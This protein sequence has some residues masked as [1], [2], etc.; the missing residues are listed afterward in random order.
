MIKALSLAEHEILTQKRVS[1]VTETENLTDEDLMLQFQKGDEA[2][3]RT[4]VDRHKQRVFNLTYRFLNGSSDAE[5]L[6]QEIFMKIY[7]SKDTYKP[8]AK[9]TTWLFTITR[10]ACFQCLKK[11]GNMVSLNEKAGESKEELLSMVTDRRSEN[12]S[13]TCLEE[14]KSKII[15]DAV[16]KLPETQRMVILL[17]RFEQLSYEEIAEVLGVTVQSVK[18]LLFRGRCSLKELLKEY[19]NENI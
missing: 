5:D 17:R 2:C 3:F 4:L 15:A 7:F 16:A 9:F 19:F 6:A 12:P 18:S 8:L 1:L 11:K 13:E 10:N 14:E